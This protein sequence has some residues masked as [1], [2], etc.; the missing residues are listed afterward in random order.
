VLL[1]QLLG[2]WAS[3]IHFHQG[4]SRYGCGPDTGVLLQDLEPVLKP[5]GAFPVSQNG[6]AFPKTKF[7]VG[8]Q[9]GH[10]QL[11]V[12]RQV[13]DLVFQGGAKP[14]LLVQHIVKLPATLVTKTVRD[15][16]K[17]P[18]GFLQKPA[19]HIALKE[20]ALT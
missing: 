13:G 15:N 8:Q 11:G 2:L 16:D 3:C 1:Y 7:L 9:R 17:H 14:N 6:I 10:S 19:F 5:Q 20:S 4:L 12:G 18:D